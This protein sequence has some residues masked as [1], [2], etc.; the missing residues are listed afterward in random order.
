MGVYLKETEAEKAL[1]A[2]LLLSGECAVHRVQSN[3]VKRGNR[4][5]RLREDVFGCI[6][7]VVMHPDDRF[8]W[9]QVTTPAGVTKRRRKIERLPWPID[10]SVMIITIRKERDPADG[11]RVRYVATRHDY[12]PRTKTWKRH[13]DA[14]VLRRK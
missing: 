14:F 11:R 13:L 7:L 12:N 10:A 8:D 2:H 1:E 6:D 3:V 4:Y 5:M 9:I